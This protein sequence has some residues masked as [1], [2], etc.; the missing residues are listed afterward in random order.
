MSTRYV[1]KQGDHLTRIARAHGFDDFRIVWN[2][3][4]NAE[5]RQ[6]RGNPNV[7]FPGDVVFVPDKEAK[8]ESGST[9]Q[10][11]RFVVNAQSLKLRV[12]WLDL[13]SKPLRDA[14]VIL[15]LD[16]TETRHVTNGEG[17]IEQPINQSADE[18]TIQFESDDLPF[19]KVIPIEVHVGHLDPVETESGQRARLDALGYD[20]GDPQQ[21]GDK[22]LAFRSAAEEFQCDNGLTVDGKVRPKTRA[23]LKEVYGC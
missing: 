1:V 11:H 5:L 12:R 4:E 10:R 9:N 2:D 22:N 19:D 15:S 17:Q 6:L 8:K 18:G 3:A 7:L 20:A 13:S 16:G 14:S 23:K 21:A